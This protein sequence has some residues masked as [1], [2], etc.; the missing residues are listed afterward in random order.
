M[1]SALKM[2][3][4]GKAGGIDGIPFEFYKTFWDI[5][6]KDIHEVFS[7]SIRVGRLPTSCKRG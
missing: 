3:K 6:G 7:Y 1:T 5:L 2:M 4:N